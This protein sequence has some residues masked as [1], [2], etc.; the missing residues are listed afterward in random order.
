M[1]EMS[2]RRTFSAPQRQYVAQNQ[3][4]RKLMLALGLLV[5]AL[6]AVLVK[7]RQFWFGT[8]QA[9]IESD[10]P[11]AQPTTQPVA[12]PAPA[13]PVAEPLKQVAPARVTAQPKPAEAPAVAV[14]R[15]VLP[16]LDVEVVAGDAHR[17]VRQPSTTPKVETQNPPATTPVQP[18]VAMAAP[19]NAAE[20]EPVVAAAIHA[21]QAA[22]NPNYPILASHMNVQGSVVLQAIISADGMI[23]DLRVLSGPS[24][25]SLAAQQAVREW[26]FKPIFQNGQAVESKA[27]ITVNFSIRV[28]DSSPMTT[29]AESRTPH[30]SLVT[31]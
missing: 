29:V 26:R 20:R 12:Q 10:M 13:V 22:V 17:A 21:P 30:N 24:I 6:V 2:Q 28:A 27:K 9:T 14:N 1:L 5:V 31:R 25:L 7:D 23:E 16:P 18:A 19:T 4:P 8:E 15:T 11:L 3:Q